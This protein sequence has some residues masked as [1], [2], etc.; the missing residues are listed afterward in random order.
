[1]DPLSDDRMRVASLV[2]EPRPDAGAGDG[3]TRYLLECEHGRSSGAYIPAARPLSPAVVTDILT[4]RH[5]ATWKCECR[6]TFAQRSTPGGPAV[7]H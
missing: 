6:P 1:M 3:V 5:R 7:V 2:I 4:W